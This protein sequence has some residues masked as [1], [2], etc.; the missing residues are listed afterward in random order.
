MTYL[1]VAANGI[2]I[3]LASNRKSLYNFK[4]T[5]ASMEETWKALYPEVPFSYSFLDESIKRIY[6]K[7]NETA[8]LLS[9]AMVVTIFISCIGLF[10]LSMFT[11]RQRTKEMGIRKVLGASVGNITYLLS[12]NVMALVAVATVIASP[13]AW[14]TMELWLQGYVY[15]ISIS[16]WIF[17]LSGAGALVIA[18][19]TISWQTIRTALINPVETL[20]TE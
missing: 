6:D 12:R 14:Y 13:I 20:R 17:V 1:P 7:E 10:G 2:A 4:K 9:A 11:A 16:P 15:R 5:V 3:K 8:F 18:L 19:L